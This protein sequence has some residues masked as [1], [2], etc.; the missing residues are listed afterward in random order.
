VPFRN[1]LCSWV[2]SSALSLAVL[3][4]SWTCGARAEIYPDRPVR[5]IVPIGPGGAYDIIGRLL[6][7]KL[8]EQVGQTFFVE[9]R[10]G[11]GTLVGTQAA[12]AAPA[13]GYTL[14]VGGLSNIVFNFALYQKVPYEPDDFVPVALVYTFPYVLVARNDLPEKNLAEIIS[15]GRQSPGKLTVAHPGSGS[16][17]QIVAAAFMKLTGTTIV[18]VP[19]R[20]TQAAYP[21]LI[22]GRVDLLFDSVT[23]AL[24]YVTAQRVRGIAL[25]APQRYPKVP[26][27]PTMTEAGLPGL[28]VESWIGLFAPAR[29]PPE[30]LGRLRQE[31]RIAAAE[32]KQQFEK[33]GGALMQLPIAETDKFIKSEFD[34][35]TKVIRDAGIRL[36]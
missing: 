3:T 33:S 22:A 15:Y 1:F 27:L 10:T 9:N 29:T 6:A 14:V 18:E 16:G 17:Q 12:A 32:L 34:L 30:I 11:A 31:T 25:L 26:D 4:L 24:P 5:I 19:Y 7:N 2:I 8:T 13:D 20:S 21:D 36:D 28:G 35:W 23:A